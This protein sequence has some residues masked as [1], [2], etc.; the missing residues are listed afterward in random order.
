MR[1]IRRT[2]LAAAL[3]CATLAPAH[4]ANAQASAQP[5]PDSRISP[6]TIAPRAEQLLARASHGQAAV[7]ALG[8]R[9]PAAAALNRM[10]ETRLK[11]IL[12]RDP[13][14]WLGTDGR[15]FYKDADQAT[16][17]PAAASAPT[18]AYA[19]AD[20]FTLH[21]LPTSQHT[22]YLD[23]SGITLTSSS[24][25]VTNGGMSAQHFTGYSQDADP[26]FNDAEKTFIQQVWRTVAEKYAPFD[27]DVTTEAPASPDAYNRTGSGDPTWG[28][29][30]IITGDGAARTQACSGG[31][32]GVA[33]IGVFN[34]IDNGELE[35]A[36]VFTGATGSS[37]TLTGN[38]AAHE[39]GHTL[40]L[41]H[42]GTKNPDGTTASAYYNGQ[43]NWVPIMGISTSKAMVQF[44]K[45]EYTAANN[46]QDDLAVI[47]AGGAPVRGDDHPDTTGL[48]STLAP[49]SSYALDGVISTTTDKDVVAVSRDCVNDLTA[50]AT[51]IGEGSA[52]DIKLT[53]YDATGTPVGSDDPPSGQNVAYIATGIDATYTVTSAAA[54]TYYVEVDGVGHANPAT[55]GYSD[56][57]SLGQYHL[58]ISGCPVSGDPPSAPQSVATTPTSR[59]TSGSV[60]W[61]A[62]ALTGS[63]PITGYTIS[64]V[65]GGPYTVAASARSRTLTGLTPGTTYPVSVV[66]AN[67][68]GASPAGTANLRIDTWAPT[69]APTLSVTGSGSSRTVLWAEPANPGLATLTGW[70]LDLYRSGTLVNTFDAGPGTTGVAYSNL[71]LGSYGVHLT[72]Q[73]AADDTA[74]V[75]TGTQTFSVLSKP[76]APRIGTA[77]SGTAGKPITALVRWAAPTNI[78]G[79]PVTGY[80]VVASKLDSAGRV[81]RTYL[82]STRSASARSFVW[83]LPAGRYKFRVVAYNK[84]GGSAYS[85][86]SN[87][88]S[89]R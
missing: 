25:W 19:L 63:S 27:V 68:S 88:A 81:T 65:P 38:A 71:A 61:S 84:V 66:A 85:A 9:L 31:C 41:T 29:H 21:S 74:G 10:S 34:E 48:A 52:L 44:S 5:S 79:T 40:G 89:A 47:A 15:M 4:V 59:S 20:T 72:G 57:G 78:G 55:D 50:T 28:D 58:T 36:W 11:G 13:E 76:S 51:G 1:M 23:F 67:G 86:Y 30:V 56:Y 77:G 7:T 87:V 70:H 18:A 42:D 64:G 33:L 32:A 35:P 60:S 26:A 54:A 3:L 83:A 12:T 8:S 73:Y 22:I 6:R 49:A 80:K 45:G 24:W 16:A 46:A 37:A 69:S 75:L 62:P 82:S 14:A 39:I 53:V 2:T 43:A 17:T